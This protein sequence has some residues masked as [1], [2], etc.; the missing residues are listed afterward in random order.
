[1][2]PLGTDQN[3]SHPLSNNNNNNNNKLLEWPCPVQSFVYSRA[4][5][6]VFIRVHYSLFVAGLSVIVVLR[7]PPLIHRRCVHSISELCR[8]VVLRG[9]CLPCDVIRRPLAR[10]RYAA[11]G[12]IPE[13]VT[14]WDPMSQ[15][16]PLSQEANKATGIC[17][18]C[19]ATRQ[20]HFKDGTVHKHGPRNKPCQG[21]HKPPLSVVRVP[22]SHAASDP[23][24]VPCTGDS[25]CPD[26]PTRF[27]P[28]EG[29]VIKHIL[30]SA[31]PACATHL[32]GLLRAT[33]DHPEVDEN[34]LAVMNWS[35]SILQPP[36][37]R[38]QAT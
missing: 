33:T 30:K 29:G 4:F 16:W 17:S 26:T 10:Y 22:G 12:A 20:L 13:V 9:L 36:H 3:I 14:V 19:R 7:S 31:R 21:S 11:A 1:V 5:N 27:R 32:T 28:I 15:S 8:S 38:W 37:S 6:F 24:S 18:V 34:W 35:A 2:S 25:I 23:T